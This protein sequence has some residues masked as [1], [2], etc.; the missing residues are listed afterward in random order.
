MVFLWEEKSY[1]DLGLFYATGSRWPPR[2][3]A[4]SCT[5]TVR[6]GLTLRGLG[7]Q[8]PVPRREANSPLPYVKVG[9]HFFNTAG[10]FN[11]EKQL[12]PKQPDLDWQKQ[13]NP[14]SINHLPPLDLAT[15]HVRV[16]T[17]KY[18]L[19]FT[20]SVP[21]ADGRVH[22]S[23]RSVCTEWDHDPESWQRKHK[24]VLWCDWRFVV[25]CLDTL[26]MGTLA[27]T[28]EA[29]SRTAHKWLLSSSSHLR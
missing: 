6:P 22:A 29:E 25:L 20:L 18:Q 16:I 26:K 8:A 7:N 27:R 17:P 2:S 24:L 1:G 5:A 21:T 9:L 13:G 3:C 19:V 12:L 15:R 4:V 28:E 10:F 23:A 14:G 11:F